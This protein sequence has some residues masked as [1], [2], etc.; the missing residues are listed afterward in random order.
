[1]SSARWRCSSRSSTPRQR[2]LYLQGVEPRQR[3]AQELRKSCAA[4]DETIG[5]PTKR[6]ISSAYAISGRGRERSSL[7]LDDAEYNDAA[8]LD[9]RSFAS[10]FA[11]AE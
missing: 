8:E 2:S 5:E 7:R 4:Y 6:G 3:I 11:R 1:M 9:G 10:A